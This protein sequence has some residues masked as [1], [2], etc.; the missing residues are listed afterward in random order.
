MIYVQASKPMLP[1]SL[2]PAGRNGPTTF[3]GRFC[4]NRENQPIELLDFAGIVSLKA[5]KVK[6][7]FHVLEL[8]CL[9]RSITRYI[10]DLE[11]V[12][13]EY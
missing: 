5:G 7:I 9:L 1:P 13:T 8:L 12:L 3:S 4:A 10:L 6:Q 2:L 11:L